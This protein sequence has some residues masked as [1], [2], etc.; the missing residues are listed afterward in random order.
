MLVQ[1]C[2]IYNGSTVPLLSG[3]IR[4]SV[5]WSVEYYYSTHLVAFQFSSSQRS[6]FCSLTIEPYSD[7]S[8]K[9]LSKLFLQLQVQFQFGI[10]TLKMKKIH[11]GHCRRKR[12][13][14]LYKRK[15]YRI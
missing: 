9:P 10:I 12:E 15:R 1:N 5:K 8:N 13:N 2:R 7:Q 11:V 14:V 3:I 6:F 4:E